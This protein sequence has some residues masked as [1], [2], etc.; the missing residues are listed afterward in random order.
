MKKQLIALLMLSMMAITANAQ[1]IAK[2]QVVKKGKTYTIVLY[3]NKC[4]VEKGEGIQVNIYDAAGNLFLT[5]CRT[6]GGGEEMFYTYPDGTV[7]PGEI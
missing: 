2:E 3:S 4:F 7:K 5:A 6:G 1:I